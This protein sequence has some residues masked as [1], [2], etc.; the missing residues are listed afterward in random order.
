MN[1]TRPYSM[2]TR[3]AAAEATHDRIV[4]V[5]ADLFLAHAYAEVTLATIAGAAGV[6]HQTVLNHF[7]SKA[8]VVAA[9]AAV[10]G[11]RTM[12]ARDAEPGDLAGAIHALVDDYEHIGDANVRW[13]VEDIPELAPHLDGARA[14]HQAWLEEVFDADL[15]HEPEARRRAVH[16][17]HAATD[18]FV[19]KLLRRDLGLDRD[20]T[21]STIVRLAAGVLRGDE[22]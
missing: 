1:E 15:P 18:V 5:A 8:G 7:G 11:E 21:E 19:W 20:E 14:G 3:S 9:V 16:A 13:A 12:A 10:M 4:D 6:S 2:T 17:L 22:P